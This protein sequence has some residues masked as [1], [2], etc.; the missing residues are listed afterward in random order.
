MISKPACFKAYDLRGVVPTELNAVLAYRIGR[1]YVAEFA[2]PG[3]VAVGYDIRE[4]SPELATATA[5]G[6]IDGGVDVLNLGLCGTESVY[7]A[8]GQPGMGGGIMITASHNPREYNGMKL[9]GAG[10]RPLAGIDGLARRVMGAPSPL[11]VR[12]GNIYLEASLHEEHALKALSFFQPQRPRRLRIVVNA[13][14]GGAG[15]C[16]DRMASRLPFELIRVHHEPDGRFPNGIPNPLLPEGRQATAAAVREAKADFGVA[17]DGDFDRC[18]FFDE[19]GDFIDGYYV[20]GLLAREL[21]REN[22][23]AKI[24]YD[25]RVYWNTVET[26]LAAKGQPVCSR[27]GHIFI[28]EAMRRENALY[29]GEMSAHHYFRDF[30]YCDSGMIPWMLVSALLCDEMAP[31]S[32]LVAEAKRK[33]PCSGEINRKV[34]DVAAVAARVRDHHAGEA[35]AIDET[36]G[37]GMEF[38]DWR[39]NLRASQTEPLLRLNVETR[40]NPDLLEKQTQA[41]LQLM[42]QK[43]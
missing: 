27:T 23:G 37:L 18:F 13:G 34:A 2:P 39:F 38:A 25:P 21:L 42:D 14:N 10:A 12:R 1:E 24:I 15:L 32:A 28:K 16:V 33:F 30:H 29:G 35:L 31:L 22:R 6:L 8:A 41:L 36:D 4:S 17:W 20:V 9:V 3:P 26:V 40:G 7:F 11:A 43:A 5:A 19:Q